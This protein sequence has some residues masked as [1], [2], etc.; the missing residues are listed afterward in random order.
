MTLVDNHNRRI[1]YLRVSLNRSCNFN[2]IYCD[3]EGY[4]TETG[5][6]S[7]SPN[8]VEA[9]IRLFN[10]VGGIKKIKFTGG[11]PLLHPMIFDVVRRVSNIPGIEDISMT[12]NAYFLEDM[13]ADLKAAGLKRI[14][15]SLC[16]LNRD[17][18]KKITGIDGLPNVMRGIRQAINVGL[19]P[20]KLNFVLLKGINDREL[21]RMLDYCAE[22]DLWLQLIE[23]HEIDN[24]HSNMLGFFKEHYLDAETAIQ[25]I[26]IPV[27]RV[28]FRHMQ[29]RK[30]I[31]FKNGAS[32]EMVKLTPAFCENCTK[33]RITADGKIKPCLMQSG[34]E[35]DLLGAMHAGATIDKLKSLIQLAVARRRPYMEREGEVR[36]KA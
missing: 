13:A 5:D 34:Q 9:I 17:V 4:L 2:C 18:F 6:E 12:S 28:E 35:V 24:V 8:D 22:N 20:I 10:Q 33:M 21:D 11:E 1:D 27:E 7:L 23:L 26:K 19:K 36:T 14:N 29:H 16:S 31:Y 32:L 25:N 3:K 15:I 30:I